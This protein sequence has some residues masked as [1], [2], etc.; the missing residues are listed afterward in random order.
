[1]LQGIIDSLAL[2]HMHSTHRSFLWSIEKPS[3]VYRVGDIEGVV[4]RAVG[5][6]VPSVDEKGV[7]SVSLHD[8][9]W[10]DGAVD[11]PGDA[12]PGLT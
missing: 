4:I 11:E 2:D 5:R 10:D 3:A 6:V 9:F 1:M 12:P 8:Q 7:R